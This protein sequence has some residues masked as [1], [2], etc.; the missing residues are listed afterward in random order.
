MNYAEYTQKQ[1]ELEAMKPELK[2]AII[3]AYQE[4]KDELK[5][6]EDDYKKLFGGTITDA[7]KLT[8]DDLKAFV[9]IIKENPD[10]EFKE[11]KAKLHKHPKT[12]IK[13]QK[14]WALS[15]KTLENLKALLKV[16]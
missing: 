12:I 1:I 4:K 7:T 3:K 8:E 6:L 9:E 11:L 10:I 15:D 2:K 5:K 13:I 16:A 14:Q